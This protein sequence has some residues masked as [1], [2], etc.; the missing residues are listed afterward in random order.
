VADVQLTTFVYVTAME[1]VTAAAVIDSSDV[2]SD[3]KANT[4]HRPL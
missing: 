1:A 2:L 3:E 4:F